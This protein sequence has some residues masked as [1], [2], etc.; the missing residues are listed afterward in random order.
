MDLLGM[1]TKVEIDFLLDPQGQRKQI[2]VKADEST[3]KRTL[4][5]IYYDGEDVGGLVSVELEE[6]ERETTS[7]RSFFSGS[8][9]GE[10]E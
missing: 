8:T 5:Y 7:M 2:E 6:R 10:E 9:Q 1:G 3:A 4:Q